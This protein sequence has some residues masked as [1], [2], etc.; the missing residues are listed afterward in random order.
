MDSFMKIR[1]FRGSLV[2]AKTREQR[3]TWIWFYMRAILYT[4]NFGGNYE[5]FVKETSG[6]N[7]PGITGFLDFVHHP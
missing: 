7:Y 1:N 5:T 2:K 6:R 4:G 3:Q